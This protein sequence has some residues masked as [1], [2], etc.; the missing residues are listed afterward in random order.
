VI[1]GCVFAVALLGSYGL[2]GWLL[3]HSFI[4][5]VVDRP[6]ARSSHSVPTPRGGGLSIVVVTTCGVLILAA[7][8]LVPLRLA[9][10]LVI[11]GLGVAAVGFCD[12]IRSVS[13]GVRMLTH[14]GAAL[15]AVF[16]L[17]GARLA[18]HGFDLGPEF[19]VAGGI[20]RVLT[21]A[22]MLNLFNFMDGID[23]LA[24]S[25]GAFIL[26]GGAALAL[27]LGGSPMVGPALIAGAACLGFLRWN[28]PRAAVF[29][30]DV[31]SGYL[32]YTIAV[33]ALYSAQT[34]GVSLYAWAM[35]AALFLVDATL[36]LLR[37]LMLGRPIFQAHRTHAYQWVSR[38]WRSH[39]RVTSAA[40]AVNF[41]ILFPC[42][43]ACV[44]LPKAA[45]W[46]C[47]TAIL[48]L[49]ALGL[50]LGSGKPE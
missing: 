41:V 14:L 2:T 29:M 40:I 48:L 10:P 47:T 23:G 24:A 27:I 25:E 13:V 32:G 16:W 6:T 43:F 9:G 42:A 30:G 20:L 26:L 33:I 17:D 45:P 8:G 31:G 34:G 28:W 7:T 46:I 49:G 38:R 5:T 15:L 39:L 1:G 22:W 12:D 50:T 18:Q 21:V 44:E 37:R 4:R 3:R 35:L 19:A 11:G 36:T